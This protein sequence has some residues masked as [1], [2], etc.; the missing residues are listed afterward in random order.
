MRCTVAQKASYDVA[1]LL[2]TSSKSAYKEFVP[3]SFECRK[4]LPCRINQGREKGLRC[5]HESQMHERNSFLTL[6]YS[7]QN[8][9]SPKLIYS[10]WQTF[11]KDLR[12]RVGYDPKDRIIQMVTGEYGDK[13]KRPHY[14]AL[15]FNYAPS[16]LKYSHTTDRG[17]RVSTSRFIDDLWGYN[18]PETTP[19]HIGDVTIESASYVARYAA[20]KLIHG[21]DQDHDWHPIHNTSSV[22]IG[23]SWIEKFH[24][25]TFQN[26]FCVL[27]NGSKTKIPR[28]YV[29]W[30]K[31]NNPDL[32]MY[33]ISEVRPKNQAL[34]EE[35]SRKEE[36]EY[37]SQ[38][39]SYKGD[40]NTY[41]I[42]RPKVKNTILNSKFKR[43]QER[44]KL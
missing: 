10:H 31:K 15:L 41:P 14:H 4:C 39:S 2:T 44:L 27:P 28:Y 11:M 42:S 8:L 9:Q 26:G 3:F 18:D 34:M 19:S 16:D 43:L 35:I 25:H 32:F 40:Y 23:K 22:G 29:D 30:V 7:E 13:N 20:K 1:G 37:L 38:L 24:M 5:W 17:D 12:D 6:T 33:Y 21:Y 36:I